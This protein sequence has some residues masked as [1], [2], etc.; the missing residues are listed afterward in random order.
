VTTRERVAVAVISIATTVLIGLL[1]WLLLNSF[2]TNGSLRALD[3][4][5]TSTNESVERIRNVLP[6]VATQVAAG[7]RLAQNLAAVVVTAPRR[8]DSSTIRRVIQVIDLPNA[9]ASLLYMSGSLT[10]VDKALYSVRGSVL[11]TERFAPTFADLI[12]Y[13]AV[14]GSFSSIPAYVDKTESYMIRSI[15]ADSL[16]ANLVFVLS[17]AG[18]D[19][20]RTV[21]LTRGNGNDWAGFLQFYGFNALLLAPKDSSRK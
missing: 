10:N 1:S 17:D 21:R 7:E 14:A 19:S 4:R 12:R 5:L 8:V 9:S 16:K 13:D 6:T 11:K 20:V 2:D 3:A 15:G 18:L